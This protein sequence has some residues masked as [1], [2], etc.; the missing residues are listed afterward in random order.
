MDPPK[1]LTP[2]RFEL[3]SRPFFV[4]PAPFLCAI[5]KIFSYFVNYLTSF[6]IVEKVFLSKTDNWASIFKFK[7][8]DSLRKEYFNVQKHFMHIKQKYL[9]IF[10]RNSQTI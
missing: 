4:L 9:C 1:T 8:I 10:L 3:E 2:N 6:T 7:P 5:S